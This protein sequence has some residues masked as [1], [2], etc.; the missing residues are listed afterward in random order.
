MDIRHQRDMYFLFDGR[1]RPG[2]FGVRHSAPHYLA[3]CSFK[4]QDLSD[5]RPDILGPGIGHRLNSDRISSS[6]RHISDMD[7][8]CIIPVF[9]GHV[10]SH[11]GQQSFLQA[12]PFI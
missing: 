2:G 8:F 1:D 9:S 4:I 3:A 10:S 7:R 6:D 11:T 12:Y 5:R